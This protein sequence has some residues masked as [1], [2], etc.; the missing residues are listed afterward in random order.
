VLR[1]LAAQALISGVERNGVGSED[2]RRR[3]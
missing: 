3:G 1:P 2:S